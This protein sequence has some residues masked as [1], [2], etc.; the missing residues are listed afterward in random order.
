MVTPT[1]E[2]NP[3]ISDYVPTNDLS[4]V[5]V[6]LAPGATKNVRT[7]QKEIYHLKMI[8]EL[9]CITMK[10]FATIVV[11]HIEVSVEVDFNADMV[12]SG[13]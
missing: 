11:K 1:I 8:E 3:V 6:I 13:I 10:D 5:D 7:I 4:V 12:P 2:I 9:L